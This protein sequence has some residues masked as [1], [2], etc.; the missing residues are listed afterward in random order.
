VVAP[1]RARLSDIAA[2]IEQHRAWIDAKLETLQ[3]ALAAHPGSARLAEGGTILYRGQP[4]GLRVRAGARPH[5]LETSGI[6]VIV[7][8]RVPGADREA[9][10]ERMLTRWLRWSAQNDA[11]LMVPC[12]DCARMSCRP[13]RGHAPDGGRGRVGELLTVRVELEC[14]R[15]SLF[16]VA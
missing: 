4:V 15:P 7:P 14:D 3:R 6:E 13:A 12:G 11:C 2:F 1:L 10:V 5:V 8:S 16:L 9:A